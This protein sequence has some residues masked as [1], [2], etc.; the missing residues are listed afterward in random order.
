MRTKCWLKAVKGR[1][2]M[3]DLGIDRQAYMRYSYLIYTQM[4]YYQS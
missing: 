4:E 3:E 2:H 1:Y